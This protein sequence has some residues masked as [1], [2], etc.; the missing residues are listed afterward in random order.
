[1]SYS[2]TFLELMND[3]LEKQIEAMK[4]SPFYFILPPEMLEA[5]YNG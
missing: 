5:I 3:P 4:Y 1:M 2:I